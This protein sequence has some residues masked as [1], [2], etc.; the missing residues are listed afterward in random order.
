M[1]TSGLDIEAIRRIYKAAAEAVITEKT[2]AEEVGM[3]LLLI[4]IETMDAAGRT[5]EQQLKFFQ[6]VQAAL[7]PGQGAG[8]L[9][10]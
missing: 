5:R 4:V 6:N 3:A 8:G 7:K 10:N 2:G 1:D 9:L